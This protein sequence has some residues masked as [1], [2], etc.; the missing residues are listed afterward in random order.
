MKVHG[1]KE[2]TDK[3]SQTS[4][5]VKCDVCGRDFNRSY[6]SA[7]KRLSHGKKGNTTLGNV[8]EAKAIEMIRKLYS[9]LSP[10][11]RKNL[12]QRLASMLEASSE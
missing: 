12:L 9:Q 6:L 4:G 1:E 7:H 5:V 2:G 3:Q 11:S 8:D 10:A